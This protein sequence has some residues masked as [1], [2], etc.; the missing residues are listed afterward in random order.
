M[1]SSRT[2]SCGRCAMTSVVEM[3]DRAEDG[4]SSPFEGDRIELDADRLRVASFPM[5]LAGKAKRRV[6]ELGHTIIH[7]W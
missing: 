7:G 4:G 6:D 1:D 5:V 2:E 3:T